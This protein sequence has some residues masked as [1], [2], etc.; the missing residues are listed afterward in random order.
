MKP[1]Q[2]PLA[3]LVLRYRAAD[4]SGALA[5]MARV[6]LVSARTVTNV[7]ITPRSIEET[8][9]VNFRIQQAGIRRVSLL[10]PQHL[11][12]A[13]LKARLLKQKTI[14]PA[15]TADGQPLAGFVRLT[16]DLQDY[17]RGDYAVLL[18]HDRLLATDKQTVA[19]PILETGRTD[20]RL[21]AIENA[22]RDEVVIDAGDVSGLAPINRQEQAWR[23]LTAVLGNQVTQAY[24]AAE[25][26][27]QPQLAFS[28]LRRQRAEQAAARI[29]LATTLLV[30]DQS[31]TY[32]ALVQYRI[33]NETEP[34]LQLVLPAEARR[35]A[36]QAGPSRP[37]QAR[38]R[39]RSSRQNGRRRRRLPRRAE[40]RR[41]HARRR[42][43]LRQL[44]PDPRNQHP[45]R[46]E[47]RPPAPARIARV[48]RFPRHHA[49][50]RR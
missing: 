46:A 36:G 34:Y 37:A 16:L 11:A 19:L 4:Y 22:G 29:G 32:R 40:I 41:P 14:E 12:K 7:K 3:R 26:A 13:R 42:F 30:V 21:L 2:Q 31:G 18:E 1:E 33:S 25:S 20:R 17:V 50:S 28:M 43:W 10:V 23:D 44:P 48:V 27:Q 45:R 38:L 39:P 6:P 15:T 24:A 9:L 47:Y 35:R 8:L 49:A 5:L